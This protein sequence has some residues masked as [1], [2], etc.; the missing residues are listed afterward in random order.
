MGI[1]IING[2]IILIPT[3]PQQLIYGNHNPAT[4]A[5]HQHQF[6]CK[7]CC[8]WDDPDLWD[9]LVKLFVVK[10]EKSLNIHK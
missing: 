4:A 9:K 3:K 10:S 7:E 2:Q 5:I 1:I 8:F 6:V